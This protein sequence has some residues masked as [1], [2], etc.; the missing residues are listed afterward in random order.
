MANTRCIKQGYP[1]GKT[2]ER[3]GFAFTLTHDAGFIVQTESTFINIVR[4]PRQFS[5]G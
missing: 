4:K 3:Q 2:R 1:T 5:D